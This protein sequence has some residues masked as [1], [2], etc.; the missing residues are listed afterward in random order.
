MDGWPEELFNRHVVSGDCPDEFK[1]AKQAAIKLRHVGGL[2][3]ALAIC[4][5]AGALLLLLKYIQ[6]CGGWCG[7]CCVAAGSLF[8]WCANGRPGPRAKEMFNE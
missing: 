7:C 3:L 2:W 5:L 4:M 1:E 8:S 6:R